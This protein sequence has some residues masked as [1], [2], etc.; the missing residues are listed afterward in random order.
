VLEDT[1]ETARV[2]ADHF[3]SRGFSH[4]LFYADAPNWIYEERGNAFLKALEQAGRNAQTLLWHKSPHFRTDR[5]AWKRKRQWLQSE[6]KRAPKPVGV[7]AASD[8]LALE[9]LET[10]EA[11]GGDRC[12]LGEHQPGADCDHEQCRHSEAL[13]A[14]GSHRVV[15]AI[16]DK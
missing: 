1:S 11:A 14:G 6:I 2:V 7:F 5:K 15:F 13:L 8:G 4:F 9:I 3:L 12:G 16:A 10:C